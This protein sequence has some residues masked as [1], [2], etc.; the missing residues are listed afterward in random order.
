MILLA[1]DSARLATKKITIETM[2]IIVA[3]TLA[4][5]NHAE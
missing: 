4:A 5:C 3:G 2:A 1:H